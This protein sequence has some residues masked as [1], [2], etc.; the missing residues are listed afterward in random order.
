MLIEICVGGRRLMVVDDNRGFDRGAFHD[1]NSNSVY[2]RE[3]LIAQ[4]CKGVNDRHVELWA[5]F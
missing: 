1:H 2:M 5:G 3:F 4:Q